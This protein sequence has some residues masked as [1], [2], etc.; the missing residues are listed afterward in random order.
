[1]ARSAWTSRPTVAPYEQSAAAASGAQGMAGDPCAK[2]YLMLELVR[3][4]ELFGW[5][6]HSGHAKEDVVC[7]YSFHFIPDSDIDSLGFL[8]W[9]D[10]V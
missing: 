5:L 7:R 8:M 4:G 6:V 1:M 2:V 3:S 10:R 9:H